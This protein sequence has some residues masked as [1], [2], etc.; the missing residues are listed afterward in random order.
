[1][2]RE[3]VARANGKAAPVNGQ[4]SVLSNPEFMRLRGQLPEKLSGIGGADF[5]RIPW[6]KVIARFVEQMQSAKQPNQKNPPTADLLRLIKPGLFSRH[7][8]ASA[9]GW[10]KDSGGIYFDYYLQ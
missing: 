10:W 8:Q 9:N 7:L 6:D 4:D 1:M 2:V 5:S 3:A